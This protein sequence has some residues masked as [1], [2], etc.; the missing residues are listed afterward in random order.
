MTYTSIGGDYFDWISYKLYGTEK[1][2]DVLM[3]VNPLYADVVLF[4]AG[5]VLNIPVIEAKGS[6]V[7]NVPWGTITNG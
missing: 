2:A 5:I 4:D 6:N 7:S 1:Y 3:R